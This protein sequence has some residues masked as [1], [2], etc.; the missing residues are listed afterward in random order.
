MELIYGYTVKKNQ[1]KSNNCFLLTKPP[2]SLNKGM[3][4]K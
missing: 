1:I 2:S 3:V 4:E